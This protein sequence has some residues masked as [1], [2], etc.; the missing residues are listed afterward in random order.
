MKLK[1]NFEGPGAF[2][3]IKIGENRLVNCMQKVSLAPTRQLAVHPGVPLKDYLVFS[4]L[5]TD[6]KQ[7]D[8]SSYA[9]QLCIYKLPNEADK[10]NENEQSRLICCCN[11]DS[12]RSIN[13][14]SSFMGRLVAAMHAKFPD[15]V[16]VFYT[17][18][19][20]FKNSGE[21]KAL[22]EQPFPNSV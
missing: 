19:E 16:V 22:K 8:E 13:C 10:K 17:F 14:L 15:F 20:N 4:T 21:E 12:K 18:N 6:N 1:Q 7:E 11:E 2:K 9:S 5:K 3:A